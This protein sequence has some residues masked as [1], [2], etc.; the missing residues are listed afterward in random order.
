LIGDIASRRIP[1]FTRTFPEQAA[2]IEWPCIHGEASVEPTR[3][4]LLRSIPIQLN[5]VSIGIS[6]IQRFANSVIAGPVEQCA[7][8]DQVPQCVCE[9]LPPG[10]QNGNVV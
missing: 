2:K 8:L 7:G 3:P 9:L 5:T 6:N 4:H 1:R 10:I